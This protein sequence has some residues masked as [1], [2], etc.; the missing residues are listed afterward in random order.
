MN[1]STDL[2]KRIIKKIFKIYLSITYTIGQV[3]ILKQLYGIMSKNVEFI[4]A[5]NTIVAIYSII[6]INRISAR[7]KQ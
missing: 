1:M 2:M 5:A 7:M 3:L 6:T 4:V